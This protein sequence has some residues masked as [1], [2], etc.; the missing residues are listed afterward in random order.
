MLLGFDTIG[1]SLIG[2]IR[3]NKGFVWLRISY[4]EINY[5]VINYFEVSYLAIKVKRKITL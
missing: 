5:H 3:E 2:S 4:Y 1:S